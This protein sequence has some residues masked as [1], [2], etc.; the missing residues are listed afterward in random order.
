M[1]APCPADP[2]ERAPLQ[3]IFAS[4]RFGYHNSES[5]PG[6]KSGDPT[7]NRTQKIP[8]RI[9]RGENALMIC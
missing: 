5:H 6:F 1:V 7:K 2:F 8:I 4:L 9:S 3:R